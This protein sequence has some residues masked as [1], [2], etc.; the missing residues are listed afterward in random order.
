MAFKDNWPLHLTAVFAGDGLD[1]KL[2]QDFWSEEL[3]NYKSMV[4]HHWLKLVWV[5]CVSALVQITLPVSV[6][7]IPIALYKNDGFDWGWTLMVLGIATVA[8]WLFAVIVA[9]ATWV[10]LNRDAR[11]E[12][13]AQ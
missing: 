7:T 1:D 11:K 10:E 9:I 4:R 13:D 5:Y 8:A 2:A 3:F 6:V 12:L